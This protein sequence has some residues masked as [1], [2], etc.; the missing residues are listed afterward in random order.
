MRVLNLS[1]SAEAIEQA[2]SENLRAD[3]VYMYPPRQAYGPLEAEAASELI[4]N[5]L[6]RTGPIN[7]YAHVPFCRQIC[8]FCN[9][10]AIAGDASATYDAYVS[11][12]L[13]EVEIY[14]DYIE[15]RQVETLYIGGGTPSLLSEEQLSEL[16]HGIVRVGNA[17]LSKIAEVALE[18][19]PETLTASTAQGFR[20]AGI[21]RINLGVQSWGDVEFASIGRKHPVSVNELALEA[22]MGAGFANVCVDLIYGLPGQSRETWVSSL[23]KVLEY[24]PQTVCCYALT[25]RPQ[26]GYARQ[27]GVEVNDAEQ[28]Y[29]Y[30][31][32]NFMLT[33]AGYSQETHVRWSIPGGGY[34]QKKNHWS[35]QDILGF[36]A[37]ARSYLHDVDLRN[38][39]SVRHRMRAYREYLRRRDSGDLP[40]TH[41]YVMNND[42]R[43]R[44]AAILGLAHLD[45]TVFESKFAAFYHE[46]APYL[47][48]LESLGLGRIQDAVFTLSP[49]GQ[50][51]RD[52]LV[53][54]L[55]SSSV[56]DLCAEFSYNE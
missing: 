41:G 24:R 39:Y 22:A 30:D 23:R 35:G 34:L 19:A 55:F 12:L 43:A 37:G 33:E 45:L 32:A 52:I 28:Y 50:R 53:Q 9:L 38:G 2:L 10:F 31:T 1:M 16:V 46:L 40:Y 48:D 56:R 8:S 20:R 49:E 11:S 14:A 3:Y 44:K 4:Q 42:E 29:R 26:T 13:T 25:L 6:S 17:E 47:G 51:H 15:K 54:P 21:N 18:V 36:G 27:G 7:L 5:S